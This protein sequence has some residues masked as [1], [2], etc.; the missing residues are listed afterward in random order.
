MP[1]M[2]EDK[3]DA[4]TVKS[5]YMIRVSRLWREHQGEILRKSRELFGTPLVVGDVHSHSNYS[6]GVGT[7]AENWNMARASGFDFLF[8]TDH[9]SIDQ[10]DSVQEAG[11]WWG[12]ENGIGGHHLVLL[13]Q[14]KLHVSGSESPAEEYA[15]AVRAAP[16]AFIPH[17]AGWWPEKWY[18]EEQLL[19]L[20][21][22]EI[23]FAV[24]VM[25]A[26]NKQ[27]RAYDQF[28]AAAVKMWDRLLERNHRVSCLGAS[29]A[30][31]PQGI[32]S[33]WT[34]VFGSSGDMDSVIRELKAGH[35]FASEGPLVSLICGDSI[36]GDSVRAP[37]G[38]D[39]ELKFKSVYARGLHSVRIITGS[40]QSASFPC[41]D[42]EVY[43]DVFRLSVPDKPSYCRL[44]ATGAD[45][46][47]AFSSPLYIEP[48]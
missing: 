16:F 6:D 20:E 2:P 48:V 32:G 29:D 46:F 9:N 24:E 7:T 43:E 8:A 33:A 34:G 4:L 26:A 39:I 38:S 37:S 44:E 27:A 3:F 15:R 35:S 11:F 47:R 12:Q 28:D 36:M 13:G 22:I 45:D 14:D 23:P 25:N 42:A 41:Q 19:Q 5:D 18:P 40:E 31:L 1:L 17:P 10:K 30:H 21:D